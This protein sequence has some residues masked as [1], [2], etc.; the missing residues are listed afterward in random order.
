M[1]LDPELQPLLDLVAAGEPMHQQTPEAARAAFRALAVGL[2]TPESVLPVASVEETTVAGVE[3]PLPARVYRPE[4]DGS[5]PTVVFFHGGGFVIGDLDTHDD[6]ARTICR[7]TTSVVV[8]VE[9][10]LAPEH[11]FPAAALDAIAATAAVLADR[12]RYGGSDAVAVAG[13]SA[14]GNLSAV[15]AQAVPGLAAQFLM[16][17][18][19]DVPG[20]LKLDGATVHTT[21]SAWGAYTVSL[22]GTPAPGAHALEA[23]FDPTVVGAPT[24]TGIATFTVTKANVAAQLT[25]AKKKVRKGKKVAVTVRLTSTGPLT[26]QV[27]IKDG[28]KVRTTVMLTAAD[29]GVKRVKVRLPK[30][31]KRKLTAVFAGNAYVE[32]GKSGK[33]RVKVTR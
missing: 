16:Y 1:P 5:V 15:A 24:V 6:L 28:K 14:G 10:R 29:R 7:G 30:T 20:E 9:Y 17:P 18:A 11:R 8:S 13:D 32:P 2:R 31:G 22:P 21:G 25:A 19:T 3:G 23:V 4:A 33:V 12:E 27:R 26:G